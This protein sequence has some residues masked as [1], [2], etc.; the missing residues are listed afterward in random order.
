MLGKFLETDVTD[1]NVVII[2][3]KWLYSEFKSPAFRSISFFFQNHNIGPWTVRGLELAAVGKGEAGQVGR[4]EG[5]PLA[6]IRLLGS[7][8]QNQLRTKLKLTTCEI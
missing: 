6:T 1:V 7:I 4:V 2:L 8:L 3:R 5:E